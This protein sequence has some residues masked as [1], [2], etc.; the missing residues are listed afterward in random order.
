MI[1]IDAGHGGKDPGAIGPNGVK[2]KDINLKIAKLVKFLISYLDYDS[3]LTRDDDYYPNWENRVKSK[4]DELY[5]S[6]HCN[7]SNNTRARGIETFFYTGSEQG[8]KLAELVQDNLIKATDRVNRGVKENK[9]L[10]VLKNTKCPAVLI[11]IGFINNL[12]EEALLD[13][14]DYQVQISAAI[15]KA[16][17]QF[18]RGENLNN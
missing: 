10:Y 3:I 8:K 17:D 7:A 1:I 15:V 4:F 2:E 5:I 13:S 12:E 9:S 18:V 6:I 16:I 11:E 14:I